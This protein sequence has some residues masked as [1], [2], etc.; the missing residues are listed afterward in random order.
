MKLLATTAK[1][2]PPVLWSDLNVE[3]T[4]M[5]NRSSPSPSLSLHLMELLVLIAPQPFCFFFFLEGCFTD[6]F[7]VFVEPLWAVAACLPATKEQFRC[8]DAHNA[9][10]DKLE[11]ITIFVSLPQGPQWACTTWEQRWAKVGSEYMVCVCLVEEGGGGVV[12][13]GAHR[14]ANQTPLGKKNQLPGA[15]VTIK[16]S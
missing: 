11:P 3:N 9:A 4:I 10:S 7:T 2:S 6:D 14:A 13:M 12:V 8:G 1:R 15:P 16:T 5:N